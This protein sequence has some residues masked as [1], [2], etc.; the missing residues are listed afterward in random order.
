MGEVGVTESGTGGAAN[1]SEQVECIVFLKGS[2]FSK[3]LIKYVIEGIQKHFE[4]DDQLQKKW[5]KLQKET[6]L[7]IKNCPFT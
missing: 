7:T 6:K 4:A 5:I 3:Q 1:Q 2:D